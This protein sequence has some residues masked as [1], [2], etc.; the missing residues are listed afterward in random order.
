MKLKLQDEESNRTAL[1]KTI[2][3][4]LETISLLNNQMSEL[5]SNCLS[6]S[7]QVTSLGERNES[8]KA[9]LNEMRLESE[10]L[11][12]EIEELVTLLNEAK[13]DKS[14]LLK[15]LANLE[16]NRDILRKEFKNQ[17]EA[18]ENQV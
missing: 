4:Q 2:K 15:K 13:A 9:E 5:R 11:Q 3:E 7:N 10:R 18:L 14:N 17:K 16:S 1:Q 12:R 8:I 6:K